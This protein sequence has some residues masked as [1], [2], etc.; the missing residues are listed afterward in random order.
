MLPVRLQV[1][2]L[3][4]AAR[5]PTESLSAYENLLRARWQWHRDPSNFQPV[6]DMLEE[7][8]AIDPGC[9]RAYAMMAFVYAESMFAV[10]DRL[11]ELARQAR[12]YAEKALAADD[13]DAFVH[14]IA[15]VAYTVCGDHDLARRHSD[16]A[17]ELNP[18]E[19]QATL[20]R[21]IVATYSGELDEGLEWLQ[22]TKRLDPQMPEH[23]LEP[24]IECH[25]MRREYTEAIEV[26]NLWR[27][28]PFYMFDV[29][30]AC[31]AQLGH[32]EKARTA[33]DLFLRTRPETYDTAIGVEA[34]LTMIKRQ[35]DRDHWLEGYRKAGVE[36]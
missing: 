16:K 2:A 28:P 29:L 13:G 19:I 36:V 15:S 33:R 14:A 26:F 18:N 35:E 22:R 1:A 30:A 27:D 31:H 17:I 7:A 21:G 12:N 34:H 4:R 8:V 3:E 20:A 32:T 23:Y 24:L 6:I 9:A 25:Y 11:D 10:A 5:K